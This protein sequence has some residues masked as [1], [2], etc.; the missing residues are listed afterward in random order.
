M[1][2]HSSVQLVLLRHV[3]ISAAEAS[4]IL[5]NGNQEPPVYCELQPEQ[6]VSSHIL[7]VASSASI[8]DSGPSFASVQANAW[9]DSTRER[10]D[11][12]LDFIQC[13]GISECFL[14]SKETQASRVLRSELRIDNVRCEEVEEKE[15]YGWHG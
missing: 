1:Q 3:P 11:S 6:V 13:V 8:S 2:Q 9:S 12:W 15:P 5:N 4:A 10:I 14:C 7:H